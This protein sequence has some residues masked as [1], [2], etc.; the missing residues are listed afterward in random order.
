MHA[1]MHYFV[2]FAFSLSGRVGALFFGHVFLGV[3]MNGVG[4]WEMGLE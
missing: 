3:T 2:D 1:C 4:G